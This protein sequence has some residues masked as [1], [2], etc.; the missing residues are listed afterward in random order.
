MRV[1][2]QA[3][4]LA[5]MWAKG[6]VDTGFI[7]ELTEQDIADGLDAAASIGD[8]RIQEKVQGQVSPEKF[9]H[10]SAEQRQRWF[11]TGYRTSDIK[12]CDTFGVATV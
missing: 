1:E 9:T 12:G 7:E 4:C 10:G 5:G 11:L 2:L 6:A 3:D 8:D